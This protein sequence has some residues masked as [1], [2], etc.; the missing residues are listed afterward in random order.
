MGATSASGAC[1][2]Q[3]SSPSVGAL[4]TLV[5]LL[6]ESLLT[7]QCEI[8]PKELWPQDYAE[9]AL[10]NGLETYD[11]VVVGG[12]SAGSVVAS[13]LSENPQWKVLVLEAGNDP[14]Q[15]SEVPFLLNSVQG[16]NNTYLYMG[17]S[18][19]HSCKSSRQGRCGWITG[20]CLGGSG[21]INAMLYFRGTRGNYDEWCSK[22]CTGWC[23]KDVWPYFQ[24]SF[25]TPANHSLPQGHISLNAYGSYADDLIELFF[26]GSREMGVP[27]I[28]DFVEGSYIGYAKF[29]GT[30]E[31]GQRVSTAK[32]FL[33]RVADS[34]PNLKVIKNAFATKLEFNEQGDRVQAVEF[35]LQGHT[36]MKVNVGKEA[37]LSAGTVESAKLLML[38]GVGPRSALESANIP[39]LHQLPVGENLQDHVAIP[40]FFSIPGP[41][42]QLDTADIFEYLKYQSGPLS[43]IGT[44]TLNGFIKTD[45]KSKGPYPDIQLQHHTVRRGAPMGMGFL[46]GFGATEELKI[47]FQDLI[48]KGD[49]VMV[50][51]ILAQ[52]ESKGLIKVKSSSYQDALH[53]E[54]NYLSNPKDIEGLLR[55]VKY[56]RDLER[57]SAFRQKKAK[58]ALVPIEDC[59]QYSPDSEE[60]W[61]CYIGYYSSTSSHLVGTVK[62]GSVQDESACVDPRLRVKG[63]TNLRVADAS[64]MPRITSCNTYGPTIMIGERAADFVQEDWNIQK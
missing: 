13:R 8:S 48:N 41:L 56:L 6:V 11:F 42:T 26:K 43:S 45:K 34:R 23:H 7:A 40:I 29:R 31:N 27:R 49:V 16:S 4:N 60:F 47:F 62:M 5:S 14:P 55:G 17:E 10:Q 2:G 37:I 44:G 50:F 36:P 30:V 33:G 1:T 51:V 19:G 28:K 53:I 18:N 58:I 25:Q 20:K 39:V 57:T 21:A 22:G 15:E 46:G 54:P 9:E 3:C 64:I 59:K 38:S 12:G 32:G 63:V 61:R 35:V 24:K 52:P